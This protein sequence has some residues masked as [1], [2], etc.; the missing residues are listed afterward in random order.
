[1]SKTIIIAFVLTVLI[2]VTA[3][4]SHAKEIV[5]SFEKV[6]SAGFGN[7]ADTREFFGEDIIFDDAKKR[8]RIRWDRGISNWMTP[9][10]ISTNNS[11]TT[12]IIYEDVEF[13]DK[14]VLTKFLYRM[15]KDGRKLEVRSEFQD[16]LRP[17]WEFNQNAARYTCQSG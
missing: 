13:T 6:T 3:T 9:D 5:C 15:F 17:G 7:A 10:E 8:F 2:S 11:F 14:T 12:Y 16:K 4:A 1:M